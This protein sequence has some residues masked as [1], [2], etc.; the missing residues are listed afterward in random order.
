M[1]TFLKQHKGIRSMDASA[2][3]VGQFTIEKPL[4]AYWCFSN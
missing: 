1:K 4:K 2:W 3:C